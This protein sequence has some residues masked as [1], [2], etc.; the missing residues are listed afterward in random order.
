MQLLFLHLQF[1]Q[2]IDIRNQP[3][4]TVLCHLQFHIPR[5]D[6]R[7][8]QNIIDRA[9]QQSGSDFDFVRIGNDLRI[10][11]F[12]QDYLI[13]TTDNRYR[14]PYLMGHI[15]KEAAFRLI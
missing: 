3:A 15:G 14:S 7:E 10:V 11:T 6:L 13:H 9:E 2:M 8:I 4:E 12:S 5:F 1:H